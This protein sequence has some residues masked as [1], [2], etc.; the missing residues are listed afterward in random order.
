MDPV[1]VPAVSAIIA[2]PVKLIISTWLKPKLEEY[3]K[4]RKIDKLFF[5]DIENLFCE[6]LERTYKQHSSVN[7]LALQMQQ[8]KLDQIYI[9]LKIYSE[10]RKE[11]I[12][13]DK[14]D[15]IF[16]EKYRKIVVEDTAGMGKSTLLKKLFVSSIEENTSIPIFIE[17]RNITSDKDI[18]DEIIENF[19]PMSGDKFDSN[20]IR[21]LITRGDFTFFLDGYDEIAYQHK[22]KVTIKLQKFISK[23]D[24]NI[25]I[26]SSRHEESLV[27]FGQFQ[28]FQI[29][30]LEK[31]EAYRILKKYDAIT[32]C[33]IAAD[34]IKQIEQ[35]INNHSFNE[36]ESFLGNPL[37]VSLLYL[38]FK[39]KRDIP[40]SK[41]DFYRK[42]YD[43]LYES[44]DL[45]KD[46]FRRPKHSNLSC[47]ELQKVLMKL[48]YLCLR[49][50]ENSYS[51]DKLLK[52]IGEAKKSQ[53]YNE[54]RDDEIFKDITE[55]VPLLISDG[56][57]YKWNHKSFMEYFAALYIDSIPHKCEYLKKIYDTRFSIYQNMLD[58]YYD[59]NREMFD[60][61]FTS[62]LLES[63]IKYMDSVADYANQND[64]HNIFYQFLY[65]R[66]YCI[67][68]KDKDETDGSMTL[69][70]F[71]KMENKYQDYD[72]IGVASPKDMFI[73]VLEKDE[74]ISL[75]I[76]MLHNRK[77]RLINEITYEMIDSK[78][79]DWMS[80]T[81]INEGLYSFEMPEKINVNIINLLRFF[82]FGANYY[83][84]HSE[85]VK[86]YE[87]IKLEAENRDK[88]L[89]FDL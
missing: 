11:E 18:V 53:Y 69:E 33:K 84:N 19:N 64:D 77:N 34:A 79:E 56:I 29:R 30:K 48:G 87:L 89:L 81:G 54:I 28:R 7:I 27:S 20:F 83:I 10:E 68:F 50:N 65:N 49:E 37:L 23:A 12:R 38:T 82:R 3:T 71:K 73:T 41:I 88:E 85:A 17:L 21:N 26:L 60:Q 35:N 24:K 74:R 67:E 76:R 40:S 52:L 78:E 58:F 61:V 2:E 70:Y 15:V 44:H 16:L 45:T 1:L 9:P 86:Y 22:E 6:Y 31:E 36:L 5:E 75:L 62:T 43:A 80:S 47:T 42:V 59:I 14:F 32:C 13:I 46:G 4:K 55:A 51:K 57:D 63:Y 66:A 25:F 8:V 39:Y 72:I